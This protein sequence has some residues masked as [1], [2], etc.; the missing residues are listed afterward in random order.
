VTNIVTPLGSNPPFSQSVNIT[1]N[2]NLSAPFNSPPGV[3]SALQVID[4]NFKSGRV[5]SYNFNLQQEVLGTIIQVAY[6]GSQGRHL[7]LIGDYNHGIGGK[8]P[9]ASITS[10]NAAGQPVAATG[11]SMTIQ[12]SRTLTLRSRN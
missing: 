6:V 4:P 12:E 2:I 5:V 11:G 8:R 10:L 1:Q 7:R 9:I 3:G